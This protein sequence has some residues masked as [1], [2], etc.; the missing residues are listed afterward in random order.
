MIKRTHEYS[1]ISV[2]SDRF[3]EES[4]NGKKMVKKQNQK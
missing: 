2:S 1:F 3:F 4:R